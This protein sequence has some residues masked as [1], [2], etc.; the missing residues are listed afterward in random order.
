MACSELFEVV[1]GGD[2]GGLIVRTELALTSPALESRLSTGSIVKGLECCEGR[3]HYELVDGAG[4]NSGWITMTLKDKDLVVSKSDS[5]KSTS[6]LKV[7][8]VKEGIMDESTSEGS[9]VESESGAANHAKDITPKEL[10]AMRQ[11]EQKFGESRDGNQAKYDRKSFPWGQAKAAVNKTSPEIIQAAKT[12]KENAQ[13]RRRKPRTWD[14]DSDGE[15]VTL[16]ERCFMPVGE[17]SFQGKEK[18]CLVH[19][20]CVAQNVIEEMKENEAKLQAEQADKK[21]KNRLEYEIGWQMESVPKS[22]SIAERLGCM[23]APQGLCCLIYDEV[24]RKVRVAA[25]LEPAAAINLEYL[26]LALKVRH[27]VQREPLFSLDPVDPKNL[28]KTLQKKRYEPEWLAGTSVGDVMFHADYFLKE[29]ALGEYTQPIA[30]MMSVFDWSEILEKHNKPWAGREW[31]IVRKAE[32]HLAEDKTIVPRVQMGV[33]AREQVLGENGMEDAPITCPNSPLKKF[34]ETFTRNFDLIAE[35]KSVVFHLRELAK[36]SVVAKF[37]VDSG[38]KLDQGWFDLA[39]EIVAATSPEKF[40]EIPQL[41][42][43]RGL[44]RIQLQDGKL[45]DTETGFESNLHAIYGG[46]QFGLDRFDLAQRSA[47][48][49]MPAGSAMQQA[50]LQAMQLGPSGRPMFMPHRFQLTQRGDMPQGVD[51]NLDKFSLAEPERFAGTLPPCSAGEGSLESSVTLGRA[52][53]KR[54]HE[55][56]YLGLSKEHQSLL[57]SVFNQSMADRLEE[58]DAFIPPDP[59]A[60]YVM[61][62]KHLVNE[63]QM[64]LSTRKTLFFGRSFVAGEPR[65]EFPRSWANQFQIAQ[66]NLSNATQ[67]ALRSRLVPLQVDEAF[68]QSLL[69]DILPVTLPEFEKATEDGTVFRIYRLGSL[70]LRTVQEPG[71]PETLGVAFSDR[72]PAWSL[73]SA[74]SP[75]HVGGEEKIAKGKLY[76]EA[77]D[78]ETRARLDQKWSS[79]T[80]DYCHYYLVLETESGDAIVTEKLADGSTI[81]VE[82]PEG[83]EDRNSLAKLLMTIEDCKELNVTY[84]NLKLVQINHNKPAAEGAMPSIRKRYA[85]MVMSMLC[86]GPR[87]SQKS[88]TRRLNTAK[89]S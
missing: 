7:S 41:W 66:P 56:S 22:T 9:G 17:Y 61:K 52:F 23:Q 73:K 6:G 84:R 65:M 38:A 50:G 33:E 12:F 25:T 14:V 87:T 51:L 21:L 55:K 37:L 34:A 40:P 47:L 5:Q 45:M 3:L 81:M 48:P 54:F 72:K 78:G 58:G 64:L 75:G 26:I 67:A 69:K 77:V 30:G 27:Q 19:A 31:F 57:A 86:K 68:Q 43:M 59:N 49:G 8:Q 39:D 42:N 76:L 44:S 53:L 83:W 2:R 88:R 29:L 35:R 85:K 70:E 13:Q 62:L 71:L 28:E 89:M 74:N 20:E 63:E 60:A 46:V 82:N 24:S 32:V 79:K 11:Y 16:C 36:A 15:E 80:L 1:G 18:G 10:E 4:P